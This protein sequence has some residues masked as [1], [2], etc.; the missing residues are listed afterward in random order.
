M[1]QE[2]YECQFC[3]SGFVTET[4]FLKHRCKEMKRDEEFRTTLGQSAYLFYQQWMK[5]YHRQSPKKQSFLNSN[6]YNAFI[7]FAKFVKTTNMPTPETYIWLMKERDITP[8]MWNN[9]LA[10]A[11]YLEFIDRRGDP[12]KLAA[13]T[14]TTL[15]DIAEAANCEVKDVF[16][17]L[18]PNEVIHYLRTRIFTP[19]L[20]LHSSKF[21]EFFASKVTG[22]EQIIIESIIRPQQWAEKFKN[23]PKAVEA[24]RRF[25][26]DLE[27]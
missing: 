16:D 23:K 3:G 7:R 15:L 4:R 14:I 13:V 11:L 26:S 24:M 27:L 5:A 9:D 18:T 19:W 1:R 8:S 25:I 6:F 17:V 20:L 22:E 12:L 21:M 2:N 10:Y